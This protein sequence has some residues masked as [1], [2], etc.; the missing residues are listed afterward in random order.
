MR[1]ADPIQFGKR[2]RARRTQF[3]WSQT[4]LGALT[5][6]SQQ[7]IDW[8]EQGKP[9]KGPES[10]VVRLAAALDTTQEWLLFGEGRPPGPPPFLTAKEVAKLYDSLP[11][12][13]KIDFSDLLRKRRKSR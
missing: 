4:K 5:G 13:Q 8:I 11:N 9:K 12:E 6:Y 10:Y 3:G 7:N 1:E 2:V